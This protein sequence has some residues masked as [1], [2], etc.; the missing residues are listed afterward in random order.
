VSEPPIDLVSL[1][2]RPAHVDDAGFTDRVMRALPPARRPSR[3]V[4]AL[5]PG[6]AALG[7]AATVLVG[8]AA[9]ASMPFFVVIATLVIASSL[10]ATA[11]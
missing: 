8:G 10:V 4:Y 2:T 1:L 9:L 7:A 3:I 5:V 6:A 11:S